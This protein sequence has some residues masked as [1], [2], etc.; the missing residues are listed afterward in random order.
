[1]SSNVHP[2]FQDKKIKYEVS[3]VS[4]GLNFTSAYQRMLRTLKNAAEL[5]EVSQFAVDES[6]EF[7]NFSY[8]KRKKRAISM[9]PA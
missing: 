2:N 9:S 1:M 8:G 7:D 6:S 3:L 4:G 5:A